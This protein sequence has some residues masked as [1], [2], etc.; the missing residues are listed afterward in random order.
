M[1]TPRS[2]LPL[3]FFLVGAALAPWL[4]L[5]LTWILRRHLR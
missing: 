4:C 1:S 3:R 5:G 2:D